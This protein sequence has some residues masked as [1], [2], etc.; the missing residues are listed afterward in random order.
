MKKTILLLLI[1]C[2][3]FSGCEKDDICDANTVTTPRLVITF[4]DINNSTVEK[5]V[6]NL[7]II[8]DGMENGIIYNGSDLINGSTVAI[9]LKVDAKTT[10][11]HFILNDGNANPALINEDILTFNYETENI[12]VSRA[13]GFKTNY[14]LN[15]NSP[16]TDPPFV[17][18]DAATPDLLWMQYVAVENSNIANENETH[19]EIYF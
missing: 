11:F 15:P 16:N 1:S 19:L 14:T 2:F 18:T 13:C 9:P 7:K 8:A 17:H 12:F 10:T 5:N 4:Y 6:T 3:S